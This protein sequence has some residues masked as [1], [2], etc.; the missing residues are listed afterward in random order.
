MIKY[1]KAYTHD[2]IINFFLHLIFR[3]H[4]Y[5]TNVYRIFFLK[6][7]IVVFSFVFQNQKL[8]TIIKYINNSSKILLLIIKYIVSLCF[9]IIIMLM[10]RNLSKFFNLPDQ[11][12][13]FVVE[14]FI[15][16]TIRMKF[17]K[18]IYKFI[19]IS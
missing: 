3:L 1:L 6:K 15:F 14:L 2:R 12:C 7:K 9:I 13:F 19:L 18:K 17:Y 5:N 8:L 16:S 11:I 10:R 4:T